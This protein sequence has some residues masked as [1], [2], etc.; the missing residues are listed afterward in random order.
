M[1]D[2]W[3]SACT[4]HPVILYDYQEGLSGANAKAFLK[5]WKGRYLHCDG[6]AG[7]KQLENEITG[8]GID[9]DFLSIER[10]QQ[11]FSMYEMKVES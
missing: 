11:D 2:Y 1:W 4:S 9:F 3:T 6:Y 7:Y 8:I 10:E 5:E